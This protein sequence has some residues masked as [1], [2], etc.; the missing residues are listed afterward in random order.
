MQIFLRFQGKSLGSEGNFRARPFQTLLTL[1]D[2]HCG[3]SPDQTAQ[4]Y[5][6]KSFFT[7]LPEYQDF[8][9]ELFDLSFENRGHFQCNFL[10][11]HF[12]AF[13]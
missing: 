9:R 1:S 10:L 13:K 8:K 2:L 5:F 3:L 11:D 4:N 12:E 7:E 6:L